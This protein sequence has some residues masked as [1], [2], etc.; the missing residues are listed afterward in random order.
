MEELAKANGILHDHA[1][2]A[3]SDVLATV[4][5]ARLLKEKAPKFWRWA[6]E[7][8]TKAKVIEALGQGPVVCVKTIFG[9]QR[10]YTAIVKKL[11]VNPQSPNEVW[12]WDLSGDPSNLP[13]LTQEEWQRLLF[14]K[15]G[16]LRE[17]EKRL[18]IYRI[19][20]SSCPFVCSNLKVL[21]DDRAAKY[22]ID[23][24]LCLRNS[25]ILTEVVSKLGGAVT[26][27]WER[28]ESQ[29]TDVDVG[30]YQKGFDCT[31]HDR[32]LKKRIASLSTSGLGEGNTVFD[33]AD[34]PSLMMQISMNS[35]SAVEAATLP[36]VSVTK[37]AGVGANTVPRLCGME[38]A[39]PEPFPST[40]MR[41]TD[42]RKN[43]STTKPLVRSWSSST[44][45][46]NALAT[47]SRR[48]CTAPALDLE[49]Q[50]SLKNRM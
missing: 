46:A 50:N 33:D 49:P 14:A 25:E 26:A 11:A 28:K 5:L 10:G 40:L 9:Q 31:R 44:S 17:G 37:S 4:G 3:L 20:V 38:R 45:G 47:T 18:P 48:N 22:G 42:C 15:K 32:D 2:D 41:S 43:I 24:A 27:Q 13:N 8:R 34:I 1:H 29:P 12:V 19:N 35:C 30:L 36:T 16:T 39:E 23:K 7:N 21:S 6:L